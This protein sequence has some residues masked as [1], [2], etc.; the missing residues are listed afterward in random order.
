[1]IFS[2]SAGLVWRLFCQG[3]SKD[4]HTGLHTAQYITIKCQMLHWIP[5]K[6]TTITK[7][8]FHCIFLKRV[9]S[10]VKWSEGWLKGCSLFIELHP[11]ISQWLPT[12]VHS[13][14][15]P[16]VQCLNSLRSSLLQ[17]YFCFKM[18]QMFSVDNRCGLRGGSFHTS[19]LL[20]WWIAFS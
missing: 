1:M 3:L 18:H 9:L 19:S 16:R 4:S 2:R 17:F 7:N 15:K 8:S 5:Q 10:T 11:D 13:R 20:L 14:S 6:L 12:T